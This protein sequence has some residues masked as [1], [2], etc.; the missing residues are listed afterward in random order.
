MSLNLPYV[1]HSEAGIVLSLFLVFVVF[2][3][4]CSS[5]IVLEKKSEFEY[6]L[7]GQDTVFFP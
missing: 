1:I 3:S 6:S 2:E 4:Q 5:K 7:T